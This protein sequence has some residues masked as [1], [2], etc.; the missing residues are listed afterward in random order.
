MN[1]FFPVLTLT[2][3][4]FFASGCFEIEETIANVTVVR[5]NNVGEEIP[6]DA[7]D[8]R[9]IKILLASLVLILLK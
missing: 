9:L 2:I 5:I 1:R 4:A 3:I 7:A 8:V 6:V